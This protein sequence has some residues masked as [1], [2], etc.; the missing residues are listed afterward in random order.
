MPQPA[1]SRSK[2]ARDLRIWTNLGQLRDEVVRDIADRLRAGEN[3]DHISAAIGIGKKTGRIKCAEIAAALGLPPERRQHEIDTEQVLRRVEEGQNDHEI[4][5]ALNR[6]ADS[7]SAIRRKHGI[8]YYTQLR[9]SEAENADI[10]R[11]LLAGDSTRAVAAAVGCQQA[12]VQRRLRRIAH[13]IPTDLP[14]CECGKARNHGGRCA[15]VIDPEIIRERLLAGRTTADIAREFNRTAQSFKPKYVQPVIDQLT[16][17]GHTC[18]CGQPLGHQFACKVTMVAQRRTFTDAE[19]AEAT[20]MIRKGVSVAKIKV[21]LGIT[22]HSANN[23]VREVRAALAAE[24]V[25]CPCG[26]PIDHSR[27][28]TARNHS[29]R[30]RTAF[31]F[32]CAAASNM[33][34]ESRRKV[35]KL[36]RDGWQVSVIVRH[37]GESEWRV[38]QMVEELA[39][40]GQL[41]AKCAGCDLPRSHRAPC[42]KPK[43]CSCGRSRN[44]RGAC[45]RAD[46]RMNVPETKLTDEQ[47]A[48][49]KQRY[50]AR[51]SIRGIS[52]AT[53]ISF[54]VVQRAIK[55]F[56][57]RAIYK[58]GPCACGR[59]AWHGGSCWATKNGVVGKRHLTRIEQGI[60]AGMTSH[61]MAAQLKLSVMTILKHSLPIRERL[62][63]EGNS[64]A[65]GRAL[66]HRF[67]CSAR[68]DAHEMP[69]GR[70][71]FAGEA[72]AI[73]AL[74]RGEIVADIAKAA[75]VG[76]DSIWRLRRELSDD[77]RTE[78]SL[79]I[80]ARIARGG[81]LHGAA[82]MTKIRA[83]VSR[84]IDPVLRDDVVSEIYLAVIEGRVEAEQVCAVVKSF[85]SRGMAQWQSAYGSRSLD[86]KLHD[87]GG[88]TLG[89]LLDDRTALTG[90]DAIE[91]GG[92]A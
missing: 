66:N 84:R 61:A 48:D 32:T 11:R 33:P 23:I 81:G 49:L 30:G 44:H 86:Q 21:A 7:V 46:G 6:S 20:S 78:R 55:R 53:G 14:L 22:T 39:R 72:D 58:P 87:D 89:D 40:A 74:L 90:I 63:A 8:R 69:R 24:K 83:T 41:P 62:F 26:E 79:A 35:L 59:P 68:W 16:A 60:L 19:R 85:V 31:R 12:D 13:L 67:W 80:R 57:E 47:L 65:C 1:S 51:Q 28:C 5:A 56:R 91:V 73:A 38:T 29:A 27:S 17:E 92:G 37:T 18:G 34:V 64:C 15:I 70:Q 4:A 76:P 10:E 75:G 71:P 25:R 9:L 45:R 50:R 2:Y 52:R 42:S 43:L 54:S 82:L 88:R 77:Q 3:Y 36:A